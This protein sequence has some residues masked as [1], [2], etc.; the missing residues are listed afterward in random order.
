M[1]TEYG[2]DVSGAESVDTE[3]IVTAVLPHPLQGRLV[4]RV[5][6]WVQPYLSFDGERYK[7]SWRNGGTAYY[8]SVPTAS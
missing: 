5:I 1:L 4:E 3:H 7:L 8:H 6:L 2:Q